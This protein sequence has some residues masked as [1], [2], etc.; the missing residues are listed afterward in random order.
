MTDPR[1]QAFAGYLRELAGRMGL[2]DWHVTISDDPPDDRSARCSV[3]MRYGGKQ[4]KTYLSEEFLRGTPEE[5]RADLA[6][7]L[8]H[9]HFAAADGVIEDWLAADAYKA[10]QRLWEYGI[11]GVAEA[12]APLLPLRLAGPGKECG[13]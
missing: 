11:D 4:A 10:Y 2:K 5:Q 9:L 6:H 1:K 13:A 7:E 12:W 3:W 8:L